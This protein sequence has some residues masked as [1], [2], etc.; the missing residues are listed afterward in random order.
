MRWSR[1]LC[2]AAAIHA[3]YNHHHKPHKPTRHDSP[4]STLSDHQHSTAHDTRQPIDTPSAVA[5]AQQRLRQA[6]A[7]LEALWGAERPDEHARAQ[8]DVAAARCHLELRRTQRAL[9]AVVGGEAAADVLEELRSANIE[10]DAACYAAALAACGGRDGA[11]AARLVSEDLHGQQGVWAQL[12]LEAGGGDVERY[13]LAL[14][15]CALSA[16]WDM[17]ESIYRL[18]EADG[19]AP[20][21]AE[22]LGLLCASARWQRRLRP[23][24]ALATLDATVARTLTLLG[25]H[26]L[27]ERSSLTLVLRDMPPHAAA[28]LVR[29]AISDVCEAQLDAGPATS[30]VSSPLSVRLQPS[31]AEDGFWRVAADAAHEL[32]VQASEA[33]QPAELYSE[34]FSSAVRR[35]LGESLAEGVVVDE[36]PGADAGCVLRLER[37]PL[38]KWVLQRCVRTWEGG[39]L[40]AERLRRQDEAEAA[41]ALQAAREKLERSNDKWQRRNEA[42]VAEYQQLHNLGRTSMGAAI[43]SMLAHVTSDVESGDAIKARSPSRAP[44]PSA[45]MSEKPPPNASSASSAGLGAALTAVK[46]VGPKR[47]AALAT[48]GILTALELARLDD[49]QAVDVAARAGLPL[50]TVQVSVQNARL[51]VGDLI[52]E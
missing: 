2:A 11:T 36:M 23:T 7:E 46:G 51:A 21:E 1:T 25:P 40:E 8:R 43:D 28:E 13:G 39:E 48:A 15:A 32:A 37:A 35:S 44:P 6:E 41:L 10:P 27:W 52:D 47:A 50:S 38:E 42:I 20:A 3:T 4:L 45:P 22:L 14:R 31:D 30:V 18:A 34:A 19:Y 16:Q 12:L 49:S 33:A 29:A 9:G 5:L 24:P 26:L 17:A